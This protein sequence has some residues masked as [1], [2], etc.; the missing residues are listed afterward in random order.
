MRTPLITA[1]TAS[2]LLAG[3]ALALDLRSAGQLEFGADGVLFVAD[4]LGSKVAALETGDVT[5]AGSPAPIFVE[6]IDMEIADLL[7]AAPNDVVIND[8]AVNPISQNV[9]LSVH[10][11]RSVDPRVALVRVDHATGALSEIDLESAEASEVAL[12]SPP[13]FEDVL[14]YGQSERTLTA[15]D[16]TWH[17][18]AG[19]AAGELFVAGVSNQDF[20]ST[21]RRVSYP[22]DGTMEMASVEIYHAGH[23]RQETR[24]PIVTSVVHEIDGVAYLIAAYT[25]TP[26]A[27]F[28]LSDLVD[29]AH[30]IGE[31]VAELGF[32]NAPVDMFV[33]ETPAMMGG[34]EKLLVTN[35]QR[36]A[37]S[38]STAAIATAEPLSERAFGVVGLDQFP[39]PLTGALHTAKLNERF[40]VTIRRNVQSGDVNLQSVL[41]GP[42]FEVSEFIVE[43]NWPDVPASD[44]PSTNPV[45]YGFDD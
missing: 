29:G 41:N 40:A 13:G 12:P 31:T 17:P 28:R 32:G 11:G 6:A 43:S 25:C 22:F 37:V 3:P 5:H 21:L 19:D 8:M 30:V 20:A 23:D 35:D 15:T 10:V 34:G 7:G 2:L 16:L 18:E 44:F 24:A 42:F 45:R 38:I 39:L 36:S 4:S 9:Y 1:A 14:Q 27:R 26:V 33:F